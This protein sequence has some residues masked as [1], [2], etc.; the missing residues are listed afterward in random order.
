MT[1]SSRPD[2]R[3]WQSAATSIPLI[4]A[5]NL[6][7]VRIKVLHTIRPILIRNTEKNDTVRLSCATLH[8]EVKFGFWRHQAAKTVVYQFS[9]N[10][11]C[12]KL[13]MV[14]QT[15]NIIEKYSRKPMSEICLVYSVI[16]NLLMTVESEKE[17]CH[18]LT[19]FEV[20]NWQWW[21]SAYYAEIE[22]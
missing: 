21:H 5:D 2:G 10:G 19:P 3:I 11:N 8:G 18:I 1:Y 6:A 20:A 16:H 14:Q 9:T 7:A 15:T 17:F 4:D 22:K 13:S 12:R